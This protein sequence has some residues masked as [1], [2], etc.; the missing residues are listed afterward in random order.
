MIKADA[1]AQKYQ[2]QAIVALNEQQLRDQKIDKL[3]DMLSKRETEQKMMYKTINQL[4]Q[5]V[6][7][8]QTPQIA[9]YLQLK[10]ELAETQA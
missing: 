5:Q 10:E 9:S 8:I 2:E 7:D 3:E 1:K 4:R 6:Q